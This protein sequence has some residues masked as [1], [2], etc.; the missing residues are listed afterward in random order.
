MCIRDRPGGLDYRKRYDL[1]RF[2]PLPLVLVTAARL[3]AAG[4]PQMSA[5]VSE[6]PGWW[7]LL[8]RDFL[9]TAADPAG[10]GG[11]LLRCV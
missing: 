4:L 8:G 11:G 10:L 6:M 1:R 9:N 5:A 7:P 2:W 3:P